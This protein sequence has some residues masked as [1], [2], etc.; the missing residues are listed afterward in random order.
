[1][2]YQKK[3]LIVGEAYK[4]IFSTFVPTTVIQVSRLLK[5]WRSSGSLEALLNLN[6]GDI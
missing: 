5:S 2:H 6:T 4:K 3:G 1:M